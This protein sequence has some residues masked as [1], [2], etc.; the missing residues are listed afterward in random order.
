[1]LVS[2]KKEQITESCSNLYG[3]IGSRPNGKKKKNLNSKVTYRPVAAA[4]AAAAGSL[5]SCPT[6]CDPIDSSQKNKI[7]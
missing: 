6:L 1:M 7:K 5:Q 3:S 2:D 4:A